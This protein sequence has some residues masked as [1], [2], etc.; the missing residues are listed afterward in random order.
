MAPRLKAA[1]QM[2]VVAALSAVA[3]WLLTDHWGHVLGLLPFAL[4]F[5]CPLMHLFMHGRHGHGRRTRSER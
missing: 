2:T 5:S 3:F 1:L 4:F